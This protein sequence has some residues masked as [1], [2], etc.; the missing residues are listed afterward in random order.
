[1]PEDSDLD[2]IE[3]LKDSASETSVL[4]AEGTGE[5]VVIIHMSLKSKP[6]RNRKGIPLWWHISA[7]G[8]AT[9]TSESLG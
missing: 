4:N 8:A 3:N 2:E 9:P 6:L 1:M 7:E 5:V